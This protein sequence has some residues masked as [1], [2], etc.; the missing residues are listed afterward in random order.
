LRIEDAPRL[1]QMVPALAR[2]ADVV[3]AFSEKRGLIHELADNPEFSDSETA[4]FAS[5]L[6]IAGVATVRDLLVFCVYSLRRHPEIVESLQ[7]DRALIPMFVEEVLRLEPPVHGLIRRV[8]GD[9]L[10]AGKQIPAGSI[11][12]LMLAAANRDP[13]KFEKPD[14]FVLGRS[15]PRH[16][17]FGSGIHYCIGSHL[18]RLE[19]EVMVELLLSDV[20]KFVEDERGP[21]FEFGG[22]RESQPGIRGIESW[23]LSFPDT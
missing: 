11:L 9:T 10:L 4:E 19:A 5:F 6:M 17:S 2:P 13:A 12:W 18:G 14:D 15:G 23:T 16:L 21:R 7:A 8:T 20:G 3:S 22:L 1:A